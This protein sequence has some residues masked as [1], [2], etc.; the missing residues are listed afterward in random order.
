MKLLKTDKQKTHIE[1]TV[2]IDNVSWQNEL[3]NVTKKLVKNVNM[4]GFRKGKVPFSIAEK[5]VKPQA[6]STALNNLIPSTIT[7]FEKE[8]S[9]FDCPEIIDQ[10]HVSVVDISDKSAT[11][12]IAYDIMPEVTIGAYENL[13]LD[14]SS[15]KE[16][17]KKEVDDEIDRLF[18]NSKKVVDSNKTSLENDD[19]A[20]IDFVGKMDG[21]EFMGG[22]AKDFT[23]KIG[24]KSF[25]DNFEEQMIG[26]KVG[27]TRVINV[28]FPK[29]YQSKFHAGKPAE[30]TVTLNK[31]K[32]EEKYEKNDEFVQSLKI[33]NVSTMS[34]LKQYLTNH[35]EKRNLYLLKEQTK[36]DL[37]QKLVDIVELSF[38]PTYT[39]EDEKVRVRR[40]LE[41]QAKDEKTTIDKQ[42]KEHNLSEDGL[43]KSI[44]KDALNSLKYV[45]AIEKIADSNSIEFTDTDYNDYLNQISTLYSVPFDEVEKRFSANKQVIM[46]EM[47]NE[48]V[49]DFILEQN[50]KNKSNKK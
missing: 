7:E 44:E 6:F 22:S 31:I 2:E 33:P 23:L 17:S 48:K 36:R 10:P 20:I 11:I 37:S 50:I 8:N 41:K 19:L 1:F 21:K 29:D 3:N 5:Q 35:F 14:L 40:I 47:L 30:F 25:I 45:F 4:Q 32:I 16:V 12:N 38:I 9:N 39:F 28:T 27:E 46:E 42:L 24:S 26:M 15:Y 43:Q 18:K 49:V 34:D 13:G